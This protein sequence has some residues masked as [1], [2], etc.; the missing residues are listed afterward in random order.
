MAGKVYSASVAL[1]DD[2]LDL[3]GSTQASDLAIQ[4]Q[5]LAAYLVHPG[6][7]PEAFARLRA[8]YL[9]ALPQLAA[10]PE[11]VFERD[12]AGLMHDGDPRWSF[13]GAA[14]IAS[15]PV[16]APRRLLAGMLARNAVEVTIV[17]D[18]GLAEAIDHTAATF[19]ALPPRPP[20]GPPPGAE[21]HDAGVRF[22]PPA[23]TPVH[24]TDT[25]RPDQALAAI[26][27]P[28]TDFY[29]D[30]RGARAMLLA[31]EVLQNRVTDEL[32]IAQGLTYSPRAE[33]DFSETLPGYGTVLAA[34]ETPPDKI[35]AFYAAMSVIGADLADKPVGADELARARNPRVA[36]IEKARLGNDYWLEWLSGSAGDPRR[37]DLIRTT[38]PDYASLG[39][40]EVE[41]AAHRWLRA[42]R[43]WKLVIGP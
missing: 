7:R 31:G 4:L 32:R 3:R 34:V 12:G 43:A 18:I 10:T 5:V 29:A 9:A 17:G 25:G 1:G 16:D 24:L 41:A 36:G 33:V 27:W 26:A 14:A 2:A 35:P 38:L 8:G 13:P 15:A 40:A 21:R 22:P 19:G 30:M 23:A 6:F 42:D 28:T 11:G 37:L 39:A 20:P